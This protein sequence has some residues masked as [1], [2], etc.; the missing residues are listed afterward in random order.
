MAAQKRI[1]NS[2]ARTG[3]APQRRRRKNKAGK[4]ILFVI[5]IVVL[6]VVVMFLY[7]TFMTTQKVGKLDIPEGAIIINETIKE[8]AEVTMKGYRN[9]ALFGV[10]STS[11]QL[12]RGTRSD[13]IIVASINED[14]GEIRLVSVYRDTYLNRGNDS[15]NKCNGAY[16]QGGPEQA[17]NM[18]NMNMDMNIT[19]FVTVGFKGLSEAIDA[20]GGVMI[21]VDE[22][23]LLHINNYQMTMAADLKRSYKPVENAGYQRLDGLQATAYCRIRYTLG[24]DFKRAERQR[25]VLMA[26]LEEAKKASPATLT[27]IAGKVFDSTL[28]S[29]DLA[30]I[31]TM[32]VDVRKYQVVGDGGFPT[33]SLRTTGTIGSKGSCIVPLDLEQNVIWLHGFLFENEE[34]TPSAELRSFSEKIERDTAQ[35]VR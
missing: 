4:I 22:V 1:Q 11:G 31:I 33:A 28:T 32:L 19:D 8:T 12:G 9:V 26:T 13:A 2:R 18:L 34:Y 35:Y 21:E 14:S 24:D 23:E 16:A 15:Y 29:F 17:I 7:S 5:E 3:K 10:D 30:D 20:L 6:I 25:E 27:D